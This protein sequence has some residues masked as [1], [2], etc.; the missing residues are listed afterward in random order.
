MRVVEKKSGN[1]ERTILV[2]MI[3]SRYVLSKISA[4]WEKG[5]FFESKWANLIA[6][7]CVSYYSKYKKPPGPMIES[8]FRDW[9]GAKERDAD[10]VDMVE[11]FLNHLNGEYKQRKRGL[12]ED[13]II[14]RAGEHFNKALVGMTAKDMEDDLEAGDVEKAVQRMKSFN[15]IQLGMGHG[16]D[17]LSDF[18]ALEKAF[19]SKKE[20]ILEYPMAAGDFIGDVI[21]RDGFVMFIGPE[22]RGKSHCLLDV[23][24]RGFEQRRNVAMFQVGDM[25]QSQIERRFVVRAA[26]RPWKEGSYRVPIKITKVEDGMPEIQY[27]DRH[28]EMPLTFKEGRKAYNRAK[29]KYAPGSIKLSVHPSGSINVPQIRSIIRDW[30]EHEQWVPDI[31]VID[32]ADILAPIDRKA[33]K[34]DQINE[35]WIAMRGLSQELHCCVVTA[36]QSDADSYDAKLISMKNFSEDHRKWAHVTAAIGINQDDEE[37][38]AGIF[39]LNFPVRREGF[40]SPRRYVTIAGCLAIGN[41]CMRSVL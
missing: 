31:V 20:P 33:D 19:E 29:K 37:K 32:Y 26:K 24:W 15:K 14:D 38:E 12:N 16:I 21:E 40:N 1:I 30:E 17:L 28:C 5:G 22:K 2:A 27:E 10:T 39:R 36:T 18:S 23:S 9:A 25:S 6:G 4:H 35:S 34:R 41:P 11:R 8:L 7:W 3:V 13:Y